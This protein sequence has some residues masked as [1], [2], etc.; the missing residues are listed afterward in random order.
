MDDARSMSCGQRL[1]QLPR[2]P[3]RFV[4]RQ[5]TRDICRIAAHAAS[6]VPR[7]AGSGRRCRRPGSYRAARSSG[8]CRAPGQTFGQSLALD[9]LHDEEVDFATS[10]PV[11]FQLW[12]LTSD[13]I[14]RADIWM[15]ERGHRA[16][17]ALESGA[18]V[19]VGRERARKYLDCNVAAQPRIARPIDF[20]HPA[21]AER[22]DDLVRT[23]PGPRCE[24]AHSC[25]VGSGE[26]AGVLIKAEIRRDQK[27]RSGGIN[28][29]SGGIK[30]EIRRSRET[31]IFS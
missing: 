23:Q 27:R 9:E 1:G 22:L 17:L 31:I 21:G 28:R 11:R 3:Q 13:V 12:P 24:H 25:V 18:P 19:D 2:D 7:R 6:A 15:I 5:C 10:A 30:Q 14:Q 16:C 26:H 8:T 20:A 29:R 4:Q